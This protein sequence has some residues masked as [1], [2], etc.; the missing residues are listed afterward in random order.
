[1]GGIFDGI[2]RP[3]S[4]IAHQSQSIYIPRGVNVDS[5]DRHKSWYFEPRKDINVGSTVTGGDLYGQVVEN[6]LIVHK[7]GVPPERAW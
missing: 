2:Q 4:E 3:L 1:M 7:L 6:S 5:L